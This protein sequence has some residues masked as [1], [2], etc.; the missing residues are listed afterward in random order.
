MLFISG[1]E[2]LDSL[3]YLGVSIILMQL[4]YARV[5]GLA[6][7]IPVGDRVAPVFF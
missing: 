5:R 6:G 3:I 2:V 4:S 7:P 1:F